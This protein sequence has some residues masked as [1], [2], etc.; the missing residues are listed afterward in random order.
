MNKPF[1][2]KTAIQHMIDGYYVVQSSEITKKEYI[3]EFCFFT[4]G[5][6]MRMDGVRKT[7]KIDINQ[8]PDKFWDFL[9]IV[10]S[11]CPEKL[12]KSNLSNGEITEL[13]FWRL[14]SNQHDKKNPSALLEY[15]GSDGEIYGV[16][17]V[18]NNNLLQYSGFDS[19]E[20]GLHHIDVRTN[21]MH[22]SKLNAE[23]RIKYFV[24]NELEKQRKRKHKKNPLKTMSIVNEI[25]EKRPEIFV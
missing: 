11:M 22:T 5:T 24:L 13:T 23:K 9:Q 8:C 16:K 1:D 10:P 14:H 25:I 17:I 21:G 4:N 7:I 6:F 19:F 15:N 12:W 18:I 3:G 20:S 2:K